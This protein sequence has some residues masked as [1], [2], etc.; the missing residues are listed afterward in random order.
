MGDPSYIVTLANICQ[1]EWWLM[2]DDVYYTSTWW[3]SSEEKEKNNI[4][5]RFLPTDLSRSLSFNKHLEKN[6]LT[7][8]VGLTGGAVEAEKFNCMY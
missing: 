2:V 6:P 3:K 4:P 7:P 8:G 1:A 5:T